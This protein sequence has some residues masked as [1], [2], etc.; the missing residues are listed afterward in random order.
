MNTYNNR[1]EKEVIHLKC[2]NKDHNVF[3]HRWPLIHLYYPERRALKIFREM[4]GVYIH[5]Y[6]LLYK[7]G[8]SN[9][10]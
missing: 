6:S 3:T 8:D 4:F 7:R 10:L 1:L 5:K 2:L 9:G